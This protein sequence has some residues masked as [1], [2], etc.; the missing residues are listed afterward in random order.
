[1]RYYGVTVSFALVGCGKPGDGVIL[2][3]PILFHHFTKLPQNE[4]TD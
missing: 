4:K 3:T 1:V 2:V